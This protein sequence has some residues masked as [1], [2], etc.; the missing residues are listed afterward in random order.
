MSNGLY[1][2]SYV[3]IVHLL[4]GSKSIQVRRPIEN[5]IATRSNRTP[6]PEDFKT[7]TFY[8]DSFNKRMEQGE[9]EKILAFYDKY[10]EL[11]TKYPSTFKI[12]D[13]NDLVKNTEVSMRKIADFLNIDFDP[14]L[15][16]AS[17]NGK[18][19]IHNGRKY[20]GEENDDI[21][22]LLTKQE[23]SIIKGRIEK[24]NADKMLKLMRNDI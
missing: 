1:I 20:I 2:D 18:E 12:I 3:N 23:Q 7:R 5:I 8:S 22:K 9:V 13:F 17:Y 11:V 15:I 24:Y 6:M 14:S 21:D 16:V 19:I 10:D 4:P